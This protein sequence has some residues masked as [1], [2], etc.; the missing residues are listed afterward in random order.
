MDD[1]IKRIALFF[2]DAKLCPALSGEARSKML[3]LNEMR[4]FLF[5]VGVLDFLLSAVILREGDCESL[6]GVELRWRYGRK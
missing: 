1:V 2:D 5:I 6:R 4:R 3:H